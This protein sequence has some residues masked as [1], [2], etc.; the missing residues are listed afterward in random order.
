MQLYTVLFNHWNN[1][2]IVAN[3]TGV[4]HLKWADITKSLWRDFEELSKWLILGNWRV[5]T[6]VLNG[7][8][9]KFPADFE[10]RMLNFY[11]FIIILKINMPWN[12]TLS[13]EDAKEFMRSSL[14]YEVRPN[15]QRPKIVKNLQNLNA[16][17]TLRCWTLVQQNVCIL[18]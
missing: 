8:L 12:L 6:Q 3:H 2:Q 4:I 18:H 15:Y 16:K 11:C 9:S 17:G 10:E 1:S 5:I 7:H 14:F 13:L